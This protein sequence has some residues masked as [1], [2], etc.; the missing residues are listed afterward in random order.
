MKAI[1]AEAKRSEGKVILFIDE[2]HMILGAGAAQGSHDAAQIL[3]E[4]LADGSIMVVGATTLK[5]YRRIEKDGALA[6]R[7]N[8]VK[9][10]PPT[11]EEAV[12]I[13]EGVKSRYADKHRVR[14][15]RATSEAAVRLA[16]RYITD[17]HLPDSALD[18]LDDAAAEVELRASEERAAGKPELREVLEEDLAYEVAL[19]TGIPA[20]SVGSDELEGLKKLPDELGKWVVGQNEA[21][22][23]VTRAVRRGRLGYKE[24][25]EPIGTF[26]FLGPTGVGK[27]EVARVLNRVM[28]DRSEK[29]LVRIDMSEYQEKHTVSRLVGAPPGYIGYDDAGQLTEPVRR[30]PHTVIL[31][32]EI[33]KAHPEVLNLLLQVIEDGRLTD[34]Q[35]RV[36]DFSNT[37]IIMTSNIGGGL[38]ASAGRRKIGFSLP[39]RDEPETESALT[40]RERHVGALKETV[41]PEFLNR[42]GLR[43]VVVFN[44]LGKPEL[45]KVLDL[46]MEELNERLKGK[47]M[48]AALTA[49]AREHLLKTALSEENRGFGA[50]P[51]KQAVTID[52]EDA[53]VAG[54]LAGEF[55]KGDS[56]EVDFDPE[57]KA[58]VARKTP[59]QG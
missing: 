54:E 11:A 41:R 48:S 58:L 51:V 36:V 3:K 18:L 16:S 43:R 49:R 33:E 19:R 37:I 6:R 2:I 32:D 34:A 55:G 35:G 38:A 8:P 1:L 47:G 15:G 25:K 31:L 23:A 39:G 10:E 52:V 29:D 45:D 53:L 57:A 44:D 9:L 12:E 28:F 14:I 30:N 59:G 27:T 17:R 4:S 24:A 20:Q 46:R 56:V 26:L 42:V 5:E 50:R 22:D 40:R 21:V 7:F 13:V